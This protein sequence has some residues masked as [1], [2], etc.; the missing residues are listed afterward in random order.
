MEQNRKFKDLEK[1]RLKKIT[2]ASKF[3]CKN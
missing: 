1:E 2:N 3:Y